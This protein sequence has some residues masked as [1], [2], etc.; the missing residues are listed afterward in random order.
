MVY[1]ERNA[2]MAAG[3]SIRFR[4]VGNAGVEVAAHNRVVLVDAF[5]RPFPGVAGSPAVSAQELVHADLILVTHLHGD[6]FDALSVIEAARR[7][8][9]TVAGP[10]SVVRALSSKIAQGRLLTLEPDY[11]GASCSSKV[12]G[13][14]IQAF[15]TVHTRDHNSYLLDMGGF[16]FFHDGDNEDISVLNSESIRPLDVLF[17]GTWQGSGWP[18][19]IQNV[20]PAHWVVVHLSDDEVEA[21]LKGGFLPGICD[22]IPEGL[23]TL[24]PGETWEGCSS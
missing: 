7:T 4:L 22:S 11:Q 13:I 9:A 21:H 23:L 20:R 12:A 16:R 3:N 5:Y 15:R 1:L 24:R 14:A 19:F 17:I 18:G 2:T 6:H 8:G 10:D